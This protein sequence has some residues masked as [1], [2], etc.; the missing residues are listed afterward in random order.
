[1]I[2]KN[3]KIYTCG[4]AGVIEQGYITVENGIIT[5]VSSGDYNGNDT[6]ILDAA[7]K[8]ATPGFIDGHCHMGM[9]EDG[10]GFEGADGN[11]DTD[12]TTPHLRGFES[13]N[14]M[15]RTF[16]E[17]L[18]YGVTTVVVSPGSTNPVAGQIAAIKTYGNVID[19]MLVK[20]LLAMKFALGENPKTCYN[21]KQQQPVTRMATVAIIREQ[22]IKAQRYLQDVE[23]HQNNPDENDMPDFDMKCDALIPVLKKEIAAHF[24]AHRADD[25]CTAMRICKEFD[26]NCVIIHGTESHLVASYIKSANIPV[27]AGPIIGTRCKPELRNMTR[28]T[29]DILLKAGIQVAINTD[30]PEVPIDMLLTSVA[31]AT[32]D[33]DISTEAAINLVTINAA[34]ICG[35]DNRVGSI[36]SGK[37]GDILLFDQNPVGLLV[38]PTTVIAMGKIL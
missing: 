23:K 28:D 12:P 38:K 17:A 25:I 6:D 10:L 7:G 4:P 19:D 37:D 8:I 31:I 2:I 29:V 36:Q 35:I 18:E 9:W 27:I 3:A 33:K 24:H 15:D 14:P 30:A 22:L 5:N 32:K 11:E 16:D 21:D 20:A 26:I 34:K 1:M 13:V